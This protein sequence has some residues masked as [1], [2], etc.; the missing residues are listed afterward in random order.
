[1]ISYR[2]LKVNTNLISQHLF[3]KV[4]HYLILNKILHEFD[5]DENL[6]IFEKGLIELAQALGSK[7]KNH[8]LKC[9]CIKWWASVCYLRTNLDELKLLADRIKN[10]ILSK[11]CVKMRSV[12]RKE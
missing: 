5:N 12:D 1:M 4:F 10:L 3:D 2:I 8:R 9:D 6:T 11:K 7:R